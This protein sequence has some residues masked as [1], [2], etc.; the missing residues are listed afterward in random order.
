MPSMM[1]AT[2]ARPSMRSPAAFTID[3]IS[4][5]LVMSPVTVTMVPSGDACASASSRSAVTST[6]I[7]RPPSAMI[8]S[9][10]ALPIPDAAPVTMTV[11]PVNRSADAAE[12]DSSGMTPPLAWR[13]NSSAASWVNFPWLSST[14]EFSGRFWILSVTSSPWLI[15]P[16]NSRM[17]GPPVGW[18]SQRA[19]VSLPVIGAI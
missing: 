11:F 16:R 3:S 12:L 15:A 8:C 17:I 7:T 1:P 4:A 2:L 9:A 10:V 14:K 6:A 5:S 19:I 18:A 13:T